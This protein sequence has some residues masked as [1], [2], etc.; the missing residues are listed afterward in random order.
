MP[1]FPVQSIDLFVHP[2]YKISRDAGGRD[3]TKREQSFLEFLESRWK[4][5]ILRSKRKSSNLF[6]LIEYPLG[7]REAS[8]SLERIKGFAKKNLGPKFRS[9][10]YSLS[11]QHRV[12][13]SLGVNLG[14]YPFSNASFSKKRAIRITSWGEGLGTCPI[15]EARDL[16]IAL[17]KAGFKARFVEKPERSVKE[18]V[19][20]RSN[21]RRMAPRRRRL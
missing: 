13:G 15:N 14:V 10:S 20:I 4:N 18:T 8:K 9:V 21:M 5:A 6:I 16:Q 3:L 17:T 11:Q 2:F 7:N 12:R 19:S 1:K